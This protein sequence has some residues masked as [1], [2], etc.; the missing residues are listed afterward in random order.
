MLVRFELA[1]LSQLS[2]ITYSGQSPNPLCSS[3]LHLYTIGQLCFDVAVFKKPTDTQQK[4]SKICR[5]KL[6]QQPYAHSS[7]TCVVCAH[8]L[9]TPSPAF[10]A[11]YGVTPFSNFQE[12]CP[13][14]VVS[15][16]SYQDCC[17]LRL[18]TCRASS[19]LGK[20]IQSTYQRQNLIIASLKQRT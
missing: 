18:R 7:S 10:G 11:S 9:S 14:M 17:Y 19:I 16:L 3:R 8:L 20:L 1:K 2:F 6:V 15:K 12:P 4:P 5:A 13:R